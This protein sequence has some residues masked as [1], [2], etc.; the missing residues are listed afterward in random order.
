MSTNARAATQ[1]NHLHRSNALDVLR[2]LPDASVDL[3][4]TDPPYSSGGLHAGVR[5]AAPQTK[6][7]HS[8]TRAKYATF[9]H[10]NKDQRSWTFWCMT[11]LAEA[12][13]A[14]KG[15]GYLVCFTDWRQLPSLTDAIQGAGYIWRGVAVWDKTAGRARPRM[16]GFSQQAEFMVWATKGAVAATN[17]KT[18]LPGVF[19]ERLALP[20]RHMTEKPLGLAREVMRL[21]PPGSVVC[22][23]FAGSG[24]FLVTAKEAGHHWIG[25]EME[26]AYHDIATARLAETPV[27]S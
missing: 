27:Q 24:T 21:V 17:S 2:D 6:Y 12:Y 18:Y 1:L 22:D 7:I 16:G 5:T 25:C 14:T 26:P 9:G 11:W 15:G 3:F 20:K 13:R 4:F 10:D 19:A 8:T 23:P